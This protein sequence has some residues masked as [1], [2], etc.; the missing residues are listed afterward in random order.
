MP[1]PF[2]EP[3]NDTLCGR[4]GECWGIHS[5]RNCPDGTRNGWVTQ[6]VAAP[7]PNTPLFHALEEGLHVLAQKLY[8]ESARKHVLKSITMDAELLAGMGLEGCEIQ[9]AVGPVKVVGDRPAE[10]SPTWRT[11]VYAGQLPRVITDEI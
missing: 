3:S 1:V 8:K 11:M 5:R 9:T 2:V 7:A 4:C 6:P 10:R